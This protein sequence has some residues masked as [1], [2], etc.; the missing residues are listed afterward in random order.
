MFKDKINNR[1]LYDDFG[2][3]IQTGTQE[4]LKY[5]ERKPRLEYDWAEDNGKMYDLGNPKFKDKEVTLSCAF[6]ADDDTAFWQRYNTFF[7][8]ITKES[9]QDLYI[10]DHSHTYKVFYKNSTAFKKSLKRLKNVPKVFVKFELI[11]QVKF[12]SL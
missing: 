11:L 4:L 2:L 8:E 10:D 12:E 1:N 7:R 3:V 9:W 5:P 6:K